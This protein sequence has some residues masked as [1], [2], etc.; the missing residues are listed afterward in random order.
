MKKSG[1]DPR[2]GLAGW[3]HHFWGSGAFIGTR[4]FVLLVWNPGRSGCMWG[5]KIR[6]RIS[7]LEWSSSQRQ[8][9]VAGPVAWAGVTGH[10][11]DGCRVLVYNDQVL[12]MGSAHG[13]TTV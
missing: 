4:K 10:L 3:I 13:C 2:A 11:T 1:A 9:S 12:E 6:V 7:H 5:L 8:D